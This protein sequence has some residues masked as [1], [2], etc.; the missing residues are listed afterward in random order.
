MRQAEDFSMA[1]DC[2]NEPAE[3]AQQQILHNNEQIEM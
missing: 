2:L 1:S 3:F